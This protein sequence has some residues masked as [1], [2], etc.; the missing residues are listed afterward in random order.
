MLT[1]CLAACA[2]LSITVSEIQR[3]IREIVKKIG[4]FF[5]T[6]LYST[7]PLGGSRRNIGTPF[8]MGK[9]EWCRYPMV[10]KILRYLLF[11]LAQL[12]N[13]TDGQTYTG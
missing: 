2:N 11:I 9:L 7:P 6:R 10:K 1:N 3:D 5:N 4:K 8:G 13:V 12:T